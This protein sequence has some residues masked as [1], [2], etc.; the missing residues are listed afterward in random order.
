MRKKTMVIFIIIFILAVGACYFAVQ[1]NRLNSV[2]IGKTV[3]FNFKN[4]DAEY[5]EHVL[6]ES[7]IEG[8]PNGK[9]A[10]LK[11]EAV[12]ELI[13]YMKENNLKIVD[14][15]YDIPQTSSFEEIVEILNF[16]EAK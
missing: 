15:H 5:L 2:E 9:L 6:N 11:E 3:D 14:G 13:K 4:A 12:D 8:N 7:G 16:E 10:L 1:I